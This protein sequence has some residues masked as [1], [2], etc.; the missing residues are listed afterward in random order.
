[1][2]QGIVGIDIWYPRERGQN[3]AYDSERGRHGSQELDEGSAGGGRE[4][5]LRHSGAARVRAPGGAEG[6][7]T[8]RPCRQ[9][10]VASQKEMSPE[11]VE[12]APNLP[13]MSRRGRGQRKIVCL[14]S[15]CTWI[16]LLQW[17]GGGNYKT[18]M[19]ARDRKPPGV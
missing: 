6:A 14:E 8:E 11:L 16:K 3:L 9:G 4:G 19:D 10:R 18:L 1:M 5:M 12:R 2:F 13:G 7:V 15:L 17:R